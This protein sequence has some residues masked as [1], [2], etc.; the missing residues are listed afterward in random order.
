M[1]GRTSFYITTPIYYPNG[2][3]HFGHAYTSIACD[4]MARFARLDGR[5]VFFLT[6]TDEHG[7]KMKQSA[8]KEGI[9]P[10]ALA[11][12]NSARFK[13]LF[14]RFHPHDGAPPLRRLPGAVEPHGRCRRYLS[15]QLWRLVLRAPGGILQGERDDRRARWRAPRAARLARRVDGGED[16]SLPALGLW[17]QVARALRGQSGVHTAARA[18]QRGHQLRQERARRPLRLARHARLGRSGARRSNARH[19]RVD[20]CAD[21]LHYCRRL[22]GC[23]LAALYDFLAGRRARRRK[24]HPALS[25]HLL[26]GLPHVCSRTA[27]CS[28]AAR[29]CRSRSAM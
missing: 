4:V 20:R 9:T 21:E 23:G 8:L 18:A 12:R 2:E 22:S 25:C 27:C 29:R 17:R 28:A 19:V 15:R 13:E 10:Q 6:G 24:G 5:Q 16:L 3:P 11:D 7:L 1:S 14:A 26:A